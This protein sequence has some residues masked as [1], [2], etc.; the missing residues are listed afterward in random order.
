MVYL[1]ELERRRGTR[2]C[3]CEGDRKGK[4]ELVCKKLHFV[5]ENEFSLLSI[6]QGGYIASL[7][8]AG[9]GVKDL[10]VTK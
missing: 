5:A 6:Y 7:L 3:V 2:G 4:S 1:G 9:D 8:I 10:I